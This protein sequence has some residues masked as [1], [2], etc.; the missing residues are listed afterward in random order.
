VYAPWEPWVEADVGMFHPEPAA[1]E[2]V[3]LGY[4]FV[5]DSRGVITECGISAYVHVPKIKPGSGRAESRAKPYKTLFL[6]A[7]AQPHTLVATARVPRGHRPKPGP[8]MLLRQAKTDTACFGVAFDVAPV[9]GKSCVK[10]V[11][12]LPVNTTAG[13]AADRTRTAAWSLTT[14]SDSYLVVINRTGEAVAVD[15]IS[16]SERFLVTKRGQYPQGS[17]R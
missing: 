7:A 9:G 14:D 17:D 6:T 4:P 8:M 1:I 10:S 11:K 15:G 2:P 5:T 3:D 13:K 12:A 16:T